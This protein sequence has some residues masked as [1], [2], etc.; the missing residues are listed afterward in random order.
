[1]RC[2]VI[3][4]SKIIFILSILIL[5]SFIACSCTT[6]S[7]KTP[8]SS[9]PV[10][11]DNTQTPASTPEPSPEPAP[12]PSQNNT[13]YI[14]W[15]QTG[16]FYS[17]P[18]QT[19]GTAFNY[20]LTDSKWSQYTDSYNN[21]IVEVG[22]MITENDTPVYVVLQFVVHSDGEF[23]TI[24]FWINEELRGTE[25]LEEFLYCVFTE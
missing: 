19:I 5:I 21:N 20:F 2:I 1:M 6:F 10:V 23:D 4:K 14:E 18:N 24:G 13:N 22:G 11:Q 7:S 16:T 3:K 9:P 17:Y 8:N 12:A 25:D 15:I